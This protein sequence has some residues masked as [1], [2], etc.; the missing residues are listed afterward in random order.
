VENGGVGSTTQ[1]S[2]SPPPP[3]DVS[4]RLLGGDGAGSDDVVPR[5]PLESFIVRRKE[6][7]PSSERCS[8]LLH[9]MDTPST[10]PLSRELVTQQPPLKLGIQV[11][12]AAH[13][14]PKCLRL[15]RPLLVGGR[16]GHRA[17]AHW[18]RHLA[19]HEHLD[20]VGSAVV[21]G[22]EDDAASAAAVSATAAAFAA[23][24]VPIRLAMST[25]TGRSVWLQMRPRVFPVRHAGSHTCALSARG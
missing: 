23:S 21:G 16:P 17:R 22:G 2:I 7:F 4:F 18:H 24:A 25:V 9:G 13:K 20:L 5:A 14:A 10:P 3:P 1:P 11:G 15:P 8:R 6:N 12:A 19:R